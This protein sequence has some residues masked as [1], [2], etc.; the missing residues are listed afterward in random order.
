MAPKRAEVRSSTKQRS[1]PEM[2][3]TAPRPRKQPEGDLAI[4]IVPPKKKKKK[5]EV[6][7]SLTLD[8]NVK[9]Q[10]LNVGAKGSVAMVLG[11]CLG[12]GVVLFALALAGAVAWRIL[13]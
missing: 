8:C 10:S 9:E 3:E 2:T 6:P 12:S 4:V 7:P 5:P 1:E 13:K 11:A